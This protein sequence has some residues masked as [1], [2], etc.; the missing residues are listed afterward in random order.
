MTSAIQESP[1]SLMYRLPVTSH[2]TSLFMQSSS[3]SVTQSSPSGAHFFMGAVSGATLPTN[4]KD[5]NTAI[6]KHQAIPSRATAMMRARQKIVKR[7]ADDGGP[8]TLAELRLQ[9]GFSQSRLAEALGNSQPSYSLIEL[10]R[11]DIMLSTFEKLA[12][13]LGVT[14]D[15]LAEAIK[16][17]K[18]NKH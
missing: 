9:A 7:L 6:E 2:A 4:F 10:G 13:L 3:G 12:E 17:T 1:E 16:N 14:R 8:V 18:N 5:L 15:R 11:H